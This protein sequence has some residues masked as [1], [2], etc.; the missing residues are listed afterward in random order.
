MN[1]LF[2]ILLFVALPLASFSQIA[3]V[4][5]DVDSDAQRA[6]SMSNT[7]GR[8][9]GYRVSIFS[10]NSQSARAAAGTT[11]SRFKV[12]MPSVAA[13]IEYD[14]PFFK[15]Y[16]GYCHT[17]SEAVRLLGSLKRMFPRAVIA[18][19]TFDVSLLTKDYLDSQ[20]GSPAIKNE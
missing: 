6:I 10:D 1:R 8:I 11:L 5:V 13:T 17:R 19:S 7:I 9:N 20:T 18:N 12:V 16:V 3:R 2:V 4:R 15:V 14:N